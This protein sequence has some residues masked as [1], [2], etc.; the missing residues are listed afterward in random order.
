MTDRIRLLPDVVANQ[1]AAGEVVEYPSSV[2]KEMI[3]NSIDAGASSVTVNFRDGGHELIQIID[4]GCGMS[5]VDARMAFDRHATSKISDVEDIYRL[6]TFGFRGEALASIAAV[7]Q[8]E[9]RTRTEQ[10]E[11]GVMVRIDGGQFIEQQNIACPVGSQFLVRN[12]FY[13]VPA[14]RRFMKKPSSSAAGIKSEFR[15]VALCYPEVRFELYAN[16][17]PVYRLPVNTLAGRIVDVVGKSIKHNLLEV[18]AKTTIVDIKGFIGQPSAAKKSNAE[19]YL[20]VNGRYFRSPYFLKAILHGYD[21]LIPQ[22]AVPTYFL[23]LSIEPDRIDVN[24]SPKKTSIKFADEDDIWKIIVASVRETLGR[25]G[26]VPMMDFSD[27]GRIDIPVP[28]RGVRYDEPPALSNAAYNPFE[29]NDVGADSMTGDRPGKSPAAPNIAPHA[30]L[31]STS[32]RGFSDNRSILPDEEAFGLDAHRTDE[33]S[34]IPSE[35]F[36]DPIQTGEFDFVPAGDWTP[37]AEATAVEAKTFSAPLLIGNGYAAA[38]YGDEL[39]VVDLARADERIRYEAILKQ[40]GGGTA[41]IQSLLFPERLVLSNDEYSLAEEHAVE[42][43]SVGFDIEMQEAQ[44]I[45]VRGIPADLPTESLDCTIYELLQLFRMP[46]ATESL[47]RER[48]AAALARRGART[49]RRAFNAE[50]AAQILER[51]SRCDAPRFTP[52]GKS[53]LLTLTPDFLRERLG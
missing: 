15:R 36:S 49:G 43:A 29:I 26:A 51:L 45:E 16:D 32:G 7:S 48:I 52:S 19:Q 6:H 39:S 30:A 27:E 20:F 23:Y 17:A 46:V 24:V 18:D 12:L 44:A 34:D 4:D 11:T 33:L 1:I 35:G 10:T 9:L 25:T 14:R 40:L 41:T 38:L 28:Q 13:N 53:V 8:V 37:T 47:R 21:K 50:E 3:E 5:P 2:V 31:H 22:G 42:L